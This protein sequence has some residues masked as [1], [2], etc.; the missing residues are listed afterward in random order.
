MLVKFCLTFT[1]TSCQKHIGYGPYNH[2]ECYECCRIDFGGECHIHHN[3]CR[4]PY[5][6][7]DKGCALV[8]TQ[9][10]QFM[11]DMAFIGKERIPMTAH[12]MEIDTH[13]IET[14]NDQWRKSHDHRVKLMGERSGIYVEHCNRTEHHDHARGQR[15]GIAHKYLLLLLGITKHVVVEEREQGAGCCR[16]KHRVDMLAAYIEQYGV[17]H[18]CH[19]AQPGCK[20]VNTVYQIR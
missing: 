18:Q 15:T 9:S 20:P 11:M 5:H 4:C 8:Q 14:W 16:C 19:R 2:V 1:D 13:N 12:T 17:E 10:K 3:K 7:D 6:Y